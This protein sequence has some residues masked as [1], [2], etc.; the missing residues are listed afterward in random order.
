MHAYK[1]ID[2]KKGGNNQIKDISQ[3]SVLEVTSESEGGVVVD[4][5]HT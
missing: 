3:D 5:T 4:D 2:H 1:N